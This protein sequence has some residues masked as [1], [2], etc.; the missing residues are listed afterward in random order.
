MRLGVLGIYKMG[1]ISGYNLHPVLA[2]QIN[3][4]WIDTL[5]GLECLAIASREVGAMTLKLYI[6][7]IAKHALEPFHLTVGLLYIPVHYETRYL[8]AET[9]GTHDESL[10]MG[11]KRLL[12]SSGM[13][14]ETFGVAL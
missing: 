8:A 14:V 1:V 5:L 7:V 2:R 10:P 13:M 4:H 9:C 12:V 6:V 11:C 3:E